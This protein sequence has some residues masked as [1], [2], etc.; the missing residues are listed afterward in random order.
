VLQNLNLGETT[1]MVRA[2]GKN[3]RKSATTQYSITLLRRGQEKQRK[4]CKYLDEQY[5]RQLENQNFEH[6][7]C[8]RFC[9]FFKC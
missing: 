7:N 9:F 5:K 1:R 8:N 6:Q 4:T 3:G 2:C